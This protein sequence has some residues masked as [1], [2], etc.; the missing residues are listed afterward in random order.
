MF[1][2]TTIPKSFIGEI[3]NTFRANCQHLSHTVNKSCEQ[4]TFSRM[5]NE[6]RERPK[7]LADGKHFSPH[8]SYIPL[9]LSCLPV[10]SLE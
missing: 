1:G 4:P 7:C 9:Y 2:D 5:A 8:I 6:H 10:G 3:F